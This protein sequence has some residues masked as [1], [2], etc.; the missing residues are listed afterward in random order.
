MKLLSDAQLRA[1]QDVAKMGMQT[2][3]TIYRRSTTTGLEMT[4]DPYGSS[5]SYAELPETATTTS[6]VKGMFH[7]VNVPSTDVDSGQLVVVSHF[8]LWVPVGTDIRPGD[9]VVID[10]NTYQVS[11]TTAD[12]T[13]PPFLE[14]SLRRAE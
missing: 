8:R 4:D 13:W 10:G 11:D 7:E 14:C 12:T 2:D 5:V 9:Q 6:T 1:V 3:V